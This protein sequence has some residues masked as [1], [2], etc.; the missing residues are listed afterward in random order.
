ML[1]RVGSKKAYHLI[2]PEL[3]K[4]DIKCGRDKLNDC[5]SSA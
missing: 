4:L 2:K 3:V 5:K 1:T